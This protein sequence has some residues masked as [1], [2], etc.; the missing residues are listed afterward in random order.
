[1]I[2]GLGTDLALVAFWSEALTD[3]T[4][5]VIEGTFTEQELMD[6]KQGPTPVAECLAARFAAKEAFI[7]AIGGARFGMPP[8]IGRLEPMDIEVLRDNWGRPKLKLHGAAQALATRFGVTQT[9]VSM[10]H[11]GTM[12]AATVV[13][14]S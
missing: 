1:M 2:L 11:E 3:P 6:A 13:L 10:T 12:A 14:E 5:S 4:T 9:F 8:V 7:K